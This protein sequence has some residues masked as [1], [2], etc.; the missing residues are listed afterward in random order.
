[1]TSPPLFPNPSRVSTLDSLSSPVPPKE[2]GAAVAKSL[3]AD[4]ASVVV[5]YATSKAG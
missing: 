3:A 4:G 2:I 5:N 1:M